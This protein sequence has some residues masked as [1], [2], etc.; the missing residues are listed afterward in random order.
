MIGT[1]RGVTKQVSIQRTVTFS[2]TRADLLKRLRLPEETQLTV[3]VPS[4]DGNAPLAIAGE[5]TLNAV[6]R[7]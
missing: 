6:V 2:F 1:K 5:V 3:L 4:P 7:E